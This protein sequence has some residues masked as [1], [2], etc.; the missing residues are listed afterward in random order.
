[1]A[2]LDSLRAEA[3]V[4]MD[5]EKRV[6]AL[7]GDDGNASRQAVVSAKQQNSSSQAKLT[8]AESRA[9]LD[10]GA[11]LTSSGEAGVKLRRDIIVG[12]VTL[13]RAEFPNSLN[14][15]ARLRYQLGSTRQPSMSLEFVERSRA[16]AQFSAGDSAL[17][18]LRSAGNP[19]ASFRPGERLP[20]LATAG[21]DSHLAV[22]A[23]A[24][25]AYQGRL[26]CYVARSA[27]RF[28]RVP[29]N[30]SVGGVGSYA[31]DGLRS[32]DRV[33]VKG[34]ALLLSL[35]QSASA[36]AGAGAEE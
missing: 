15:A 13:F 36:E 6:E 17:L 20:V 27:G 16:A 9:R 26:W 22:P 25:I 11:R 31:V 32:D 33:V 4:A 3:A 1:M 29:L 12:A 18:A 2:D 21:G 34:A 28:D 5:N 10:W 23:A 19:D 30:E 24:A 35:E 8:G 14:D 7:F